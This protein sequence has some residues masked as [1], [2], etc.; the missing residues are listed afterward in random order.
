MEYT[1]DQNHTSVLNFYIQTHK[2]P[3]QLACLN[4]ASYPSI[5][6]PYFACRQLPVREGHSW[7]RAG[8]ESLKSIKSCQAILIL[9]RKKIICLLFYTAGNFLEY[10][11]FIYYFSKGFTR[12]FKESTAHV[13]NFFWN[14]QDMEESWN[15]TFWAENCLST[16]TTLFKNSIS[17]HPTTLPT[18]HYFIHP[19]LSLFTSL[20]NL[21]LKI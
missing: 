20:K 14:E 18:L 9:K 19:F 13:Q 21:D 2:M 15:H 12:I 17:V 3:I 4:R 11:V 5:I 16:K 1:L 6:K 7:Y 10:C 8:Q